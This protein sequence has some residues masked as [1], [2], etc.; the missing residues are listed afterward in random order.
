MKPKVFN[1]WIGGL[2]V[3]RC[4]EAAVL[5]AMCSSR[6]KSVHVVLMEGTWKDVAEELDN[7]IRFG[8]SRGQ[9]GIV[10]AWAASENGFFP[11]VEEVFPPSHDRSTFDR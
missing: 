2:V 7:I 1:V 4:A 11:V 9:K 8:L 6:G 10:E 3:S 5:S